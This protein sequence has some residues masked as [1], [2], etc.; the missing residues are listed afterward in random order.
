MK[1]IAFSVLA[2]LLASL[3]AF[4]QTTYTYD[5]LNRLSMV[6]YS[7]G[8]T[9]SY[10][11]DALGNRTSKKV[12]GASALKEAYAWLSSDGKTLT[13]CYD[14]NRAQ[15]SGNTYDL[16]SQDWVAPG[17]FPGFETN[18]DISQI[19]FEPS[20]ANARPTHTS[21]WFVN[22]VNVK[23]IIGL[24]YLNTSN[25]K[26]MY[27]MFHGSSGLA[28]LDL[29]NFDTSNVTHMGQMFDGCSGLK[30]ID[31]GHFDISKVTNMSFMFNNCSSLTSLD[32]SNLDFSNVEDTYALIFH[33][34]SLNDLI[35]S[36]SMED[37]DQYACSGVGT[38]NSPCTIIAPEGFDFGVDTS[39]SYFVWKEGI[40]KLGSTG[41]LLGDVNH[42][43]YINMSDVTLVI[44]YILGKNPTP[45]YYTEADMNTD[46]F[47]NMS[48]VTSIIN[49]I[50]GRVSQL[51]KNI[52]YASSDRMSIQKTNN[53]YDLCLDNSGS[54]TAC[55]MTLCL[56][57]GCK[58][59]DA[60]MGANYTDSHRVLSN[61][62][63]D[64]VYRL[65][66]YSND[67][68]IMYDGIST[69]IHLTVNGP[70]DDGVCL[71][72]ILY[73][74]NTYACVA[75][76]NVTGATSINDVKPDNN[77]RPS[78]NLQGVQIKKNTH[79]IHVQKGK[80]FTRK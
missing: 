18:S 22:M 74:D 21:Y 44:N 24:K 33:C 19:V 3:Q 9:V 40:F 60:N 50:L 32:L 70:I 48:D 42:D 69:L 5:D 67:S 16:N 55:E 66:V 23:E 71:S 36:S 6:T 56:P 64:G 14:D 68:E 8:V 12:I 29:S 7:N 65:A 26:N 58:L 63:G 51:P 72:D 15:R 11:Y 28:S 79:G 76:P 77:L 62:V 41:G 75:F 54:Y 53:G 13:F 61:E 20:F 31:L 46:K 57:Q 59:I 80:K 52:R 47:I 1:Q 35:I 38:I 4:A 17:W 2:F 37:I 73:V 43:G 25:V 49:T 30:S 39:G 27:N 10:T 34:S 78:Y 45:F